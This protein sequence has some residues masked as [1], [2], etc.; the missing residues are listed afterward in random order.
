MS[1]DV[2]AV[3]AQFPIFSREIDGQPCCHHGISKHQKQAITPRIGRQQRMV[4]Q[5]SQKCSN[6]PPEDL[7]K[8]LHLLLAQLA[9]PHRVSEKHGN[10]ALA[11]CRPQRCALDHPTRH[12]LPQRTSDRLPPKG[13]ESHGQTRTRPFLRHHGRAPYTSCLPV[14]IGKPHGHSTQRR[15]L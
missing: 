4:G 13:Q 5:G 11:V 14:P 15:C 3:R 9:E 6:P 2:A 7:D 12:G 8:G 10:D 1:L